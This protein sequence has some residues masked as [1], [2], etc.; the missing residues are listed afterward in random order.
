M[1]T[2]TWRFSLDARRTRLVAPFVVLAG[3]S[4]LGLVGCQKGDAANPEAAAAP[5]FKV[6]NVEVTRIVPGPFVEYIRLT[7][8]AQA[9]HD[10]EIAAEEPGRVVKVFVDKGAVVRAGQ[11]LFQIDDR[12]L[13]TQIA[14]AEAESAFAADAFERQG[15]VWNNKIGTELS[16]LERKNAAAVTAANLEG[17]RTRLENTLIRAPID[18]TLAARY[19]D[20]G[21]MV[22]IGTPMGR[23]LSE[24]NIQVDVGVPE[25]YAADIHLGGEVLVTFD[26]LPE[27]EFDGEIHFVGSAVDPKNRTFPI[28]IE[29]ENPDRVIKPEMIANTRVVRHRYE[30]AMV[31]PQQA[32]RYTENGFVAY[33]AVE[34][35]NGT[36]AEERL[37]EVGPSYADHVIVEK[38]LD[39][40][41]RLI[42]R[43]QLG[44]ADGSHLEIVSDAGLVM[45]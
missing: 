10:I 40:G 34:T 20:A 28:E 21:E 32:I 14:T 2:A 26:V 13:R 22:A 44:V 45:P 11:R 23:L 16:Y 5:A 9:E 38:G 37:V 25:R 31:V 43:G 6:I 30:M 1:K 19:I 24:N 4:A 29:L 39:P 35:E 42:T 27:I 3:L 33:V 8:V 17:L 18:G 7:G 12:L 41:D 15:A 36:L